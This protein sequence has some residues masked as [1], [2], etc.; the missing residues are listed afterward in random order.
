LVWVY[1]TYAAVVL[2]SSE[3]EEEKARITLFE[4][5]SGEIVNG[6]KDVGFVYNITSGGPLVFENDKILFQNGTILLS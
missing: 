2:A 6:T 3:E 1:Y 4:D 5:G